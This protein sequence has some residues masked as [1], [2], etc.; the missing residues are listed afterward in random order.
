MKMPWCWVPAALLIYMIELADFGTA[1]FIML[2][3]LEYDILNTGRLGCRPMDPIDCA[4]LRDECH[5]D[6]EVTDM[7]PEDVRC[8]IPKT[9]T[10]LIR[11]RFNQAESTLP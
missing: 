11:I 5:I 10:R 7:S 8:A 6:D 9:A 3:Y 2:K 1:S 4:S